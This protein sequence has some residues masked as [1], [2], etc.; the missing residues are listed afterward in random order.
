MSV[1]IRVEPNIEQKLRANFGAVTDSVIQQLQVTLQAAGQQLKTDMVDAVRSPPKSG[2][3]YKRRTIS[4]QA[5]APGEAPASDT[6]TLLRSIQAWPELE[7]L[8]I[9]VG[10]DTIMTAYAAR[11]EYG[12]VGTDKAGRRYN[13]AARPFIR[14]AFNK[15]KDAIERELL[16]AVNRGIENHGKR[17]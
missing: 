12:F 5:S 6:G 2:R 9:S 16:R 4:H 15:R 17:T 10:V 8:K 14:P 1:T 11:L 13:M 7:R 3:I